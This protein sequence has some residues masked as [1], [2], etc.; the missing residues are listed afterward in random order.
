MDIC[1]AIVRIDYLSEFLNLLDTKLE[2]MQA[3]IGDALKSG[4]EGPLECAE[5]F[6]GSG[7]VAIQHYLTSLH[8]VADVDKGPALS[9]GPFVE[10]GLSYAEGMNAGANYWKH[11]EEWWRE[12]LDPKKD[13]LKGDSQKTLARLEKFTPWADYTCANLLYF[14]TKEDK[15]KLS[16]LLPYIEEWSTHVCAHTNQHS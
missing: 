3:D 2:T 4:N 1:T 8:N 13:Q 14:L 15:L 12:V 5:Y 9:L 7:F 6:I 11:Q 16:S 10:K